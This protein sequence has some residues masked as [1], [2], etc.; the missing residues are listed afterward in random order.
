MPTP[1]SPLI[2]LPTD[3]LKRAIALQRLRAAGEQSE[4]GQAEDKPEGEFNAKMAEAALIGT[5]NSTEAPD[6]DAPRDPDASTTDTSG[7]VKRTFDTP[8]EGGSTQGMDAVAVGAAANVTSTPEEP[9]AGLEGD[10]AEAT[11]AEQVAA[12]IEAQE[13]TELGEAAKEMVEHNA[14]AAEKRE[15]DQVDLP[16]GWD[17]DPRS[18]DGL[19]KAQLQQK[20]NAMGLE[21]VK[22]ASMN[23]DEMVEAIKKARS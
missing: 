5:P 23:R 18:G 7:A 8:N 12:E 2:V 17:D 21:D 20:A 19:T 22:S 6:P 10:P 16:E 14:E 11:T 15:N 13:G 4:A 9:V 1:D 3:P